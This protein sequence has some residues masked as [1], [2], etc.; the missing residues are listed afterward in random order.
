MILRTER[1]YQ[2][3]KGVLQTSR[4]F[5]GSIDRSTNCFCVAV[6]DAW[7]LTILHRKLGNTGYLNNAMTDNTA[8]KHKTYRSL[9]R[10]QLDIAS[11]RPRSQTNKNRNWK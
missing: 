7:R 8:P 4:S 2:R 9:T 3:G 5:A 10:S 6:S 1:F 11:I